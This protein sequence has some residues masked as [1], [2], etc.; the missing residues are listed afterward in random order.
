M[1]RLSHDVYFTL[2]DGSPANIKKLIDDC[3][4]YLSVQPGIAFFGAGPLVPDL[5][6][7]VNDRDFHV[8]LH[9]VF[10]SKQHHDDYQTD[11]T[12]LKFIEENKATW[13]TVRVFD[14]YID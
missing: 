1:P 13:K 6:R 10:E 4:K 8:A 7:P 9:V 14:S 5:D 12:H 3:R 11:P 2:H